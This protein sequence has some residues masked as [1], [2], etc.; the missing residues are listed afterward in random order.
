MKRAVVVGKFYPPHAGHHYLID[1]ALAGADHVT[2]MVC[3]APNQ[4]IPARLRA[5]WLKERHPKAHI[6]VIEDIGKDDDSVAWAAYTIQLLGYRPDV[7]FTSEEYGTPWCKAMKCEHVLVDINRKTYPVSGTKVRGNPFAYWEFLSPPVRAYYAKRVCVVGAE[8]TGTTTLSR[9]L[10]K[11]YQ[12]TWAPEYG[13]FYTEGKL[14]ANNTGSSWYTH[15]FEH[16]ADLQ[17]KAEDELARSCNKLLICDTNAFATELWH[18][19]YMGGMSTRVRK[20]TRKNYALYIVTGDEIPFEQDGMRDGEHIRHDMHK[21]F[22]EEL[23]KRNLP[24]ILVTGTVEQRLSTSVKRISAT[25]NT[26]GTV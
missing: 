7:A 25:L 19:R 20:L 4:T 15:E 22:I 21:R 9:A 1:T 17:N 24:Y 23:K 16:I 12:T 5:K 10:A 6:K 2:V 14:Q 18:E 3:D 8:S 11:H 13:R 26:V